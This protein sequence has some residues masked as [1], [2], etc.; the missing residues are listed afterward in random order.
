MP[1]GDLAALLC[2]LGCLSVEHAKFYATQMIMSVHT[3]HE[4]G[5]IHR[6]LKPANFLIDKSGHLKLADFGLSKGGFTQA[7]RST[8]RLSVVSPP[9]LLF[10]LCIYLLM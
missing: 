6:D 2:N 9:D 4:L 7:Y 1:G 3:L 10:I 8:M 5:Y